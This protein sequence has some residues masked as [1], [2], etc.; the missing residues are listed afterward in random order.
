MAK[1]AY[2]LMKQLPANDVI[3]ELQLK[4]EKM[5]ARMPVVH[6]LRNPALKHRHWEKVFDI[7]GHILD[8]N[9]ELTMGILTELNVWKY[10]DSIQEISS[11]AS[12]EAA[13]E[14]MLK[15]VCFR[16]RNNICAPILCCCCASIPG[17]VVVYN[18]C[19]TF[20]SFLFNFSL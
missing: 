11:G 10:A 17:V 13:L 7:I 19:L 9:D 2:S 12:S 20:Y 8:L 5:K 16:L 3:P 14:L 18:L 6:D 1:G 4:I 15:K